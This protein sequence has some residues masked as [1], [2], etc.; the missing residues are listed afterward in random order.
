MFVT[1]FI[2]SDNVS[3]SD[4]NKVLR[5]LMKILCSQ[6]RINARNNKDTTFDIDQIR[7]DNFS[8]TSSIDY[9]RNIIL[10][11]SNRLNEIEINGNRIKLTPMGLQNC[12][13]YNPNF[14]RDF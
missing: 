9:F 14:Q 13:N 8:S 3:E 12:S 6:H 5:P 1:Y 10:Q 4:V 2:M 11:I 7:L